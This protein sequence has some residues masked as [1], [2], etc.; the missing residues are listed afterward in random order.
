MLFAFAAAANAAEYFV[1]LGGN[2]TNSGLDRV[3]AFATVR[4]G[5]DALK[6]GDTLTILP[7]EY[8]EN[9]RRAGL[10]SNDA[11][12]TIR[13]EIPGTAVLRGDIPVEGFKKV[14]GTRFTYVAEIAVT[15]EVAAV[16]ELDTLKIYEKVPTTA[17]LNFMPGVF[18][19][20]RG[21]GKIYIATSDMQDAAKH[22]YTA[23]VIGTHGLCL[24]NPCRVVIE[25]ITV[26]GFNALKELPAS[27]FSL[28]SVWGILLVNARDCILRG[29]NAYLNG[30]GI[31]V[32]STA[33]TS[34]GNLV[35]KCT[36]WAN[37]THFGS[38]DR[39]GI[40]LIDPRRD[41]VRD[42]VSF[43]NGEW[44]INIRGGG[45]SGQDEKNKSVM[46]RNLAW[47]NGAGDYKIKTGYSYVHYADRCV[48]LGPWSLNGAGRS[49]HC[50]IGKWKIERTQ[51]N[52]KLDEEKDLDMQKEFADPDNFD[53]R[54]QA[55][56]RFRGSA[57]GGKDRGPFQCEKNIFYVS[58]NGDDK[59]DGL[60]VS[61]A[62]ETL[63]RASRDIRAGDTLYVEPGVYEGDI[64]LSL[65]GSEERPILINGRGRGQVVIWGV[66]AMKGVASVQF[67]R[68][69]FDGAVKIGAGKGIEFDHCQ[70][71][72]AG[73]ALSAEKASGLKL[74]HCV[75]AGFKESGLSLKECEGV[76]LAGNIF[77]NAGCPAVRMEKDGSVIYSDYNAYREI[78]KGR[79]ISG[80]YVEAADFLK[81]HEKYS[82]ELAP[83]FAD[84]GGV[85]SLKNQGV[86]VG[87]G[88]LG[89]P[90]GLFR[91]ERKET[92][93]GLVEKPQVHS[94]SAT[95]A[96]IE[97][98]T[99]QPAD[100]R[101]AWG[102]TPDC[103]NA[104][105]LE[106]MKFGTYSLTGL[107]PGQTNYFR[108][109][110][111]RTPREILRNM[112]EDEAADAGPVDLD[113][114]PL[115]FTNPVADA[116]PAIYYVAP[117]GNDAATGLGRPQA[118][119]TIQ[120]AAGN[121]RPG[122]TVL[123]AG[124]RYPE[125]VRIRVTGAEGKPVTFKCLPGEKV[126][127]D[128]AGKSLNQGVVAAGKNHLRFDGIYFVDSNREPLQGAPY[129]GFSAEFNLYRCRDI[130]ITRC[131]SEGRSGYSARFIVAWL[132]ED[133]LIQNC[134]TMNK[135]SGAFWMIMCLRVR[136]DNNVIFRPMISAIEFHNDS[137]FML[138]YPNEK[139]AL[140]LNGNIFTDMLQKKAVMN[141]GL[142]GGS[143]DLMEFRN[144]CFL[145]RCFPP[146]KREVFHKMPFPEYEK[147]YGGTQ[148]VYGDPKF[149]GDPNP[150][151]TAGFPP[152]RMMDPG[153]KLDFNSFFATNPEVVKRGIGL[154]PE[155]FK[156]Y[157]FSP[158]NQPAK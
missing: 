78:S 93:M 151:N 45:L 103:T 128:G 130:A 56:S 135:M 96:N 141:I 119:R 47:G 100:C 105:D 6:P 109:R 40:T 132:V 116:S 83:E 27:E 118:W 41:I 138:R 97:W 76:L 13:A 36:V 62:W 86:F 53:F 115:C 34:G 16:N 121:V 7:G 156:D 2:D 64:E 80:K 79:E 59:A 74:S 3:A 17:E 158:T 148:T 51:E 123:L 57:P 14:E 157:N 25:G 124:G 113:H 125:R 38:G 144:N 22:R 77:D 153:L 139:K 101:I 85:K 131:F 28:G 114:D 84:L 68:L 58:T 44:G 134:V 43:L 142:I 81:S 65:K 155:A 110:S 75:L 5:V 143:A 20:D 129:P 39:G 108:I 126:I 35:E 66:V 95:T 149:A 87:L 120:H 49:D 24:H 8:L 92:K 117:D 152:D 52:I 146:D 19:H 111:L 90:I 37:A 107:E 48:G 127:V 140:F 137:S 21:A 88:P 50:L 9:V 10:G 112:A 94:L 26:S 73:T 12:T 30:Q 136:M 150:T 154:Q 147:K 72:G 82:R 60:S 1:A 4:K 99:S 23:T 33:E 145:L 32:N 122:D 133:L 98:M 102:S 69:Y 71:G 67:K 55:T 61:N 104:V 89:R 46:L 15:G 70:F 63:S 54:L 31:G 18:C 11:V 29:C 91:D 42:S 106:V